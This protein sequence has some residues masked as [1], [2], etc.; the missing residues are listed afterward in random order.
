MIDKE[1]L[2]DES[3]PTK[4][5]SEL[6]NKISKALKDILKENKDFL[7]GAYA[8]PKPAKNKKKNK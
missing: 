8:F 4:K 5:L 1:N 7:L 6:R 2:T 3:G